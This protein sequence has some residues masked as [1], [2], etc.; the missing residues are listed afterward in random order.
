MTIEEISEKLNSIT[1]L[2][3]YLQCHVVF[4]NGSSFCIARFESIGSTVH[5]IL[6]AEY[7]STDLAYNVKQACEELKE[8]AKFL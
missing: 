3:R 1:T 6:I 7:L 2:A 5:K 4:Y 8:A